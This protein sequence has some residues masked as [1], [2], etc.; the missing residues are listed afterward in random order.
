MVTKPKPKK[1]LVTLDGFFRADQE[2]LIVIRR[3]NRPE[4]TSEKKA[5]VKDIEQSA[6]FSGSRRGLDYARKKDPLYPAGRRAL[7]YPRARESGIL[8]NRILVAGQHRGSTSAIQTALNALV[9][10]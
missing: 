7:D 2:D 1:K 9:A 5:S 4:M 3:E 8:S 6:P 10:N